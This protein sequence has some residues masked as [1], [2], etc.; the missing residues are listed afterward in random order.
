MYSLVS[1]LRHVY[2]SETYLC[3]FDLDVMYTVHKSFAVQG[4]S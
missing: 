3:D 2:N 1:D 4:R